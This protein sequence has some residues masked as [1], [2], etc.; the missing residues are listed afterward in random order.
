M[1]RLLLLV[2]LGL[3]LALTAFQQ[4]P[5][6]FWGGGGS[7]PNPEREGL[8]TAENGVVDLDPDHTI[9]Q[10]LCVVP[11]IPQVSSI[12]WWRRNGRGRYG[13]SEQ[14]SD[15]ATPHLRA[16]FDDDGNPLVLMTHN[17]DIADG[18]EREGE[19]DEF[20][21]QFS[22]DAYALGINIILYALNH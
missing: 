16:I 19:D 9:M 3:I 4:R 6:R 12:Q 1:R 5:K 7:Q 14:D 20:F 2:P 8:P 18:W 15:S 17:T 21:Y 22:P 11:E 10:A 13:T